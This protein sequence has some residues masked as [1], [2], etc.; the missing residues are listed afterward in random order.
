MMAADMFT[1]EEAFSFVADKLNVRHA[2]ERLASDRKRLLD[3]IA[4]AMHT[5]LIF[6]NVQLMRIPFENRRRPTVEE[7]KADIL[8][9]AG[10]LCYN[11]NVATFYLLKALGFD[12]VLV[13]ATCTTSVMVP[14]NHVIVHAKNVEKPGDTF[15]LE[16]AVGF[17][18]FRAISLDFEHESPA[19]RDSFIEYKYIKHQGKVLRMQRHGDTLPRSDL[20]DG[21]LLIIDGWRRTY[22][23]ETSGTTNIEE[24]YPCFDEVFT[25]PKASP[26]HLSLRVVGF[27]GRRAV[28]VVNGKTITENDEGDLEAKEIP[29]GDEGIAAEVKRLFPV[30]PEENIK[31]AIANW[32]KDTQS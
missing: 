13:H 32:R 2:R 27:P 10:G 28:M 30:L 31:K 8:T 23:S 3:D 22:F 6:Q 18:T 16:N 25:N 12:V 24:F 1:P 29:G 5:E 7:I 20:P 14:N 11:L 4:T 26:F 9:G 21:L 19:Y 15:L 17:P